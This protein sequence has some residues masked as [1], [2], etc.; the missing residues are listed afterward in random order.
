MG[1]MTTFPD[2]KRLVVVTVLDTNEFR[3]E[4][5]ETFRDPTLALRVVT[6]F[7]FEIEETFRVPV[8]NEFRFEIPV[9]FRD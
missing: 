2:A 9:T 8:T 3:F 7:R 6:E 5:E 4:I 1:P